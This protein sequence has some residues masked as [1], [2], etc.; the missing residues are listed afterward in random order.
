M[1][2]VM[3]GESLET[4]LTGI[5]QY[6]YNLAVELRKRPEILDFKLQVHGRLL[7]PD[8][9][10]EKHCHGSNQ[11]QVE[12]ISGLKS[13]LVGKIRA[14]A[15]QNAYVVAAYEWLMP[16]L[17]KRSL[18][19]YRH[20]DVYHSPNYILPEFPGK[21]IVSILDLSTYR[22]PEQ[23]PEARVQFV[24]AHIQKALRSAD[25][26][27]TISNIVKNEL[28]ERFKYPE[29]KITVTYLGAN[30]KFRPHSKAE[31]N[32][33]TQALELN[34]KSY[35]LFVSSIEP[36]KNL[37]RLLDAY[38]TYRANSANS[39]LPLIIAGIPG[40]KSQHIHERLTHLTEKGFVRYL[41]YVHQSLLP[42]LIAGAKS[43]LYPSLYEGF[44]LPVL[45]GM[46]SGTAVMTSQ[47]SAMTEI[48]GNA[49]VQIDPYSTDT[50]VEAL[51][52]LEQDGLAARDI[53][54]L[55]LNTAQQ[56]SWSRCADQT[57]EA[58]QSVIS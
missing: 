35:F 9:L 13:Q 41:G 22:F 56:H 5:G 37:E 18:R 25:H 16:H 45:E 48:G 17:E 12:Q 19:H 3:G 31:F 51:L 55:G 49:V 44:G 27:L 11:P 7:E 40:W 50:M 26:I 39:P 23:H 10:M 33:L 29:D 2:L 47:N 24:N 15:A 30:S 43:L 54:R 21:R 14:M 52:Q 53:E 57:F 20:N 58:Y 8:K 1:R 28:I 34:Y 36:R 6:T 32:N 38:L 46:Q 42:P 4:Q